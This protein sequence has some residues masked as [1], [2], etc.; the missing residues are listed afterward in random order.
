MK[1]MKVYGSEYLFSRWLLS[2]SCSSST[3]LTDL[4]YCL[5]SYRY[6]WNATVVLYYLPLAS[7]GYCPL[8][9]VRVLVRDGSYFKPYHWLT[10]IR[11]SY[12]EE[13]NW[14][15]SNCFLT[16]VLEFN[17]FN[18]SLLSFIFIMWL[19]SLQHFVF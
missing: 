5:H 6:F 7:I 18:H 16:D 13:Y 8:V 12:Q 19:M 15:T 11:E 9:C 14:L 4:R 2:I 10:R 1:Q 3:Y 17:K